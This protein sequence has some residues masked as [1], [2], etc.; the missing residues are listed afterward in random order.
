MS[1]AEIDA[2]FEEYLEVEGIS[3]QVPS[4]DKEIESLGC[5]INA[6]EKDIMELKYSMS[7]LIHELGIEC[8]SINDDLS[9]N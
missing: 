9:D 8:I 4:T 5:S 7:S 3:G 1:R 2:A 6:C